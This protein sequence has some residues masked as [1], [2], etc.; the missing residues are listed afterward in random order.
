MSFEEAR[1]EYGRLRQA[2]DGRQLSPEEYGRRVQGLQVRDAGGAYWAIDGNSGGWLRYDGT[3]WVPGQPPTAAAAS[4]GSF[5]GPPQGNG[6]QSQG[7][8]GQPNQGNVGSQ[9]QGGFGQPQGQSQPQPQGGYN[10]QGHYGTAATPPKRRNRGLLIGCGVLSVL[11]LLCVGGVAAAALAGGGSFSL[12]T[13]SGITDVATASSVKDNKPDQKATDFSTGQQ[14][15]LT[16]TA[17]RVKAGETLEIRLFRDGTRI[18]SLTGGQETFNSDATYNGYFTYT[19]QTAG[20]YRA[21]F[22]YNG[23]A[24]P[25]KTLDFTVR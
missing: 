5:G 25:S 1:A 9:P 10:P 19:P 16:Y 18:N 21:E 24:S 12:G 4:A 23:E 15:Y 6:G 2:Y 7:A 13:G 20:S 3:N 22:Y 8:F 11:L 14:V 17:R